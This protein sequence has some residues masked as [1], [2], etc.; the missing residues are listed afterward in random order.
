MRINERFRRV[1]M[2]GKWSPWDNLMMRSRLDRNL[3]IVRA[4]IN[5]HFIEMGGTRGSTLEDVLD[6]IGDIRLQSED[7]L[8]WKWRTSAEPSRMKGYAP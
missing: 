8:H 4:A 1:G 2:S 7:R 6:N 3:S 5:G